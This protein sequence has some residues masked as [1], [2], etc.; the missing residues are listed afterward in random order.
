MNYTEKLVLRIYLSSMVRDKC[1]LTYQT[2]VGKLDF[3]L[4]GAKSKYFKIGSSMLTLLI[5]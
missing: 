1:G 3:Q 5:A 2:V 4:P